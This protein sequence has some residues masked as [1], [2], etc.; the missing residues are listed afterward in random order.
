MTYA[1]GIALI[2][3]FLGSAVVTPLFAQTC[4][5][6]PSRGGVSADYG[7]VSF[8]NTVGATGTLAGSRTAY[9]VGVH[10]VTLGSKSKGYGGDGRFAVR[11]GAGRVSICPAVGLGFGQS[12]W[13]ASTADLKS[14]TLTGRA[15][16][17]FGLEQSGVGKLSIIPFV[18]V[19]YAFAAVK[20]NVTGS[21]VD[22]Q[23]TGD[24]LSGAGVQFG[25]LARYHIV[26][27]GF[28]GDRDLTAS[29]PSAVRGILGVT[30][31]MSIKKD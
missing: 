5:G 6:T 1:R 13:N 17:G 22:T 31:P 19:Q 2:A 3:C 29:S 8:G 7:R 11:I 18:A 4:F 30:F 24:T 9:S 28:I 25:L 12:T 26:Y 14:T 10:S 16:I 23:T 20:Y 21:D 27:V 15:G